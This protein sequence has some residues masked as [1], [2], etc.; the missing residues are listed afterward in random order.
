MRN[1]ILSVGNHRIIS[2]Y[3]DMEGQN[4]VKYLDILRFIATLF[5][6][7]I[8][9]LCLFLRKDTLGW[10]IGVSY[11]TISRWCVPVFVM[12]SGALFLRSTKE[13]PLKMLYGKYLLRLICAFI[14]WYLLYLLVF[15]PIYPFVHQIRHGLPISYEIG[16]F[17]PKYHLWF[18]P[19]MIGLYILIP[20]FKEIAR[21]VRICKYF[22]LLWFIYTTYEM[23]L[24]QNVIHTWWAHYIFENL[25][26]RT[27]LGYG[28]YFLLGYYLSQLKVNRTLFWSA[29]GVFVVVS[30]ITFLGTITLGDY[31]LFEYL[32]PNVILMS[33]SVFLVVRYIVENRSL[34]IISC[35]AEHTREELFGIYLMH[36]FIV[37]I[38][39]PCL[40]PS[41]IGALALIPVLSIVVFS[42]SFYIIK[43]LRKI[44]YVKYICS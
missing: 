36:A 43:Y 20:V 41:G 10:Y 13:V 17:I 39:P 19:M 40:K 21:N 27:V 18:L 8:H 28:G 9:V 4:R 22:L 31:Q 5:V 23:I 7:Q 11:D 26:L 14:V 32:M 2:D 3:Y 24:N 29:I 44:P 42:V 33:A 25:Q 30:V 38:I 35:L 15:E 16:S 12:I 34:N 6:I 37:S 1:L